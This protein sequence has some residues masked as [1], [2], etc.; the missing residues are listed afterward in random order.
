MVRLFIRTVN[1]YESNHTG[2]G[3]TNGQTRTE[4][5]TGKIFEFVRK[6]VEI[7]GITER[8]TLMTQVIIDTF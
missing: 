6:N 7:R 4:V 2:D 1:K 5:R 3:Q 8:R